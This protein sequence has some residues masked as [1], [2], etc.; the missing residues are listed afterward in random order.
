MACGLEMGA[1]AKNKY[2]KKRAERIALGI[3][4]D[5]GSPF[6]KSGKGRQTEHTLY[7]QFLAQRRKRGQKTRNID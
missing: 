2:A 3:A 4:P 1:S 5:F 6:S 7:M